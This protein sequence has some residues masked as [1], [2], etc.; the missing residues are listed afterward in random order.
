[1]LKLFTRITQFWFGLWLL[2]FGLNYFFEFIPQ[3][4]GVHSRYLHLAFI[5]SGLFAVGKVTD[6]IVGICLLT[7]FFVPL[8]L[9]LSVPVIFNIAWV[10]FVIEGPHPSG[11]FLVFSQLY[12]LIAFFPYYRAMLSPK[13]VSIEKFSDIDLT[14]KP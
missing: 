1:M 9:V 7:N 4:L 12:L 10:H 13:A 5:E 3:P 14:T 8:A 6:V 11:Y 2:F